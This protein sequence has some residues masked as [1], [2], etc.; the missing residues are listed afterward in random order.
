MSDA[1]E[2]TVHNAELARRTGVVRST[3]SNWLKRGVLPEHLQPKR[4][5][6]MQ[7]PY[8][9]E[10]QAAAFPEWIATRNPRGRGRKPGQSNPRVSPDVREWEQAVAFAYANGG[11][12]PWAAMFQLIHAGDKLAYKS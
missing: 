10:E 12:Q 2:Y 11:K 3:V 8:W 4:L 9:T 5:G 1:G 7:D 6:A